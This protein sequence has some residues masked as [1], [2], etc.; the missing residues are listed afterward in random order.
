MKFLGHLGKQDSEYDDTLAEFA[1]FSHVRKSL[2]D[3]VYALLLALYK[4][5]ETR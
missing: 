5:R 4:Y 2:L 3:R 1:E